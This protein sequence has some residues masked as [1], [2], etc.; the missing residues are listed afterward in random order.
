MYYLVSK[1]ILSSKVLLSFVIV[2]FTSCNKASDTN[3]D[4]LDFK[5][6]I[7]D[8]SYIQESNEL[9]LNLSFSGCDTK[10][11]FSLKMADVCLE[12]YPALCDASLLHVQGFGQK[13][14]KAVTKEVKLKIENHPYDKYFLNINGTSVLIDRAEPKTTEFNGQISSASYERESDELVLNLSYSGCDSNHEFSLEMGDICLESYPAQCSANLLFL[15]EPDQQCEIAITKE[16]RLKIENHPYD[17]Y[18][19]KINGT[20]VLIDRSESQSSEFKGQVS[21]ASYDRKSDEVVLNLSFSGCDINHEFSLEVGR[22]CTKS[23]PAQCGANL[24]HVSGAEQL[25]EM[26]I[27]KEFKLQIE[28]HPFDKYYLNIGGNSV[29]ID[30]TKVEN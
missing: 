11:A 14:E 26:L 29:L 28:N 6:T 19:L 18:Y 3:E 7:S 20:S 9:V 16:L 17:K 21:S 8:A 4:N 2:V 25:C 1:K 12:S 13:C 24:L 22:F 27:V 10:H 5:G 30:R 15:S 23:Y